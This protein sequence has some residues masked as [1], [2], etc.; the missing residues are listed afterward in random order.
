[1]P[2][3]YLKRTQQSLFTAAVRPIAS[4]IP[5]TQIPSMRPAPNARKYVTMMA[6]SGAGDEKKKGVKL[7]DFIGLSPLDPRVPEMI[8]E[9]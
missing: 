4:G 1:M 2:P 3:A 5:K 8:S 7:P 6:D 9:W